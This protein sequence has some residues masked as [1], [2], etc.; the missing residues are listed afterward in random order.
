MRATPGL[1]GGAGIAAG[2][3]FLLGRPRGKRR[4]PALPIAASLATGA[5]ASARQA[6]A[7]VDAPRRV[8]DLAEAARRLRPEWRNGRIA[9]RRRRRLAFL[10]EHPWAVFGTAAS[11]LA[12]GTWRLWRREAGK[13]RMATTIEA[14]VE[15]V[16]DAWLR[17]EDFP[18][19][20][21]MVAEVRPVGDDRWQWTIAT[22]RGPSIQLVSRVTQRDRP[23]VIAWATD[24]A[25]AQHSGTVR[26]QPTAESKTRIKIAIVHSASSGGAEE[27]E[28]ILREGL[29]AF[30][31]RVEA[32]HQHV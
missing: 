4:R 28:R 22:H 15:H 16:F 23:H 12:A 6:I 13:M 18:R 32:P 17:F 2:L 10:Q 26:F 11:L 25:V 30:K 27:G 24:G 8:T 7:R 3:M 14:P 19:F 5:V 20:M 29:A 1:V 21:P 9:L 31:A